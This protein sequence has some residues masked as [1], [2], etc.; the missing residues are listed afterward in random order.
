MPY[1]AR[2]SA[3]RR[4]VHFSPHTSS[5][6]RSLRSDELFIIKEFTQHMGRC[7]SCSVTESRS[8]FRYTLCRRGKHNGADLL[9]YLVY[10]DGRYVSVV[11]YEQGWGWTEVLVPPQ[12]RLAMLFLRCKGAQRPTTAHDAPYRPRRQSAATS[13]I[14]LRPEITTVQ[15]GTNPEEMIL[16]VTIPSFTVPVR[17]E[18]GRPRPRPF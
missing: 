9:E 6:P 11:D 14:T 2:S 10:R 16:R 4:S 1:V 3:P 5:S 17:L 12:H 13:Q 7:Q 15:D 8:T 18:Q